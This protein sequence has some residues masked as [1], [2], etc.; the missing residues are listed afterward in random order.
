M[1]KSPVEILTI[2]AD[3]HADCDIGDNAL[4]YAGSCTWDRWQNHVPMAV[5]SV[6]K[7]LPKS[8][9]LGVFLTAKAVTHYN[10][11]QRKGD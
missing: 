9:R 7:S 3:A 10:D 5:Q 2:A 4:V 11:P 1:S 8:A 6:W